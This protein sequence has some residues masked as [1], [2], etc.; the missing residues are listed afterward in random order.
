MVLRVFSPVTV[1]RVFTAPYFCISA[2]FALMP[3]TTLSSFQSSSQSV[4]DTNIFFSI[5]L[6]CYIIYTADICQRLFC[7]YAT[8]V[9]NELIQINAFVSEQ[10]Y[11]ELGWGYLWTSG[12][13]GPS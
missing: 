4:K 12:L 5:W 8:L 10:E 11:C 9:A 2:Q 7:G 1:Q 6:Q 3:S 13:C